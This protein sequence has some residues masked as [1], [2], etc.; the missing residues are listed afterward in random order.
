M[1]A[2]QTIFA[3]PNKF[4]NISIHTHFTTKKKEIIIFE[5]KKTRSEKSIYFCLRKVLLMVL[6]GDDDA[7]FIE[8]LFMIL[9]IY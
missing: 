9:N 1:I 2:P 8:N 3:N 4:S 5:S 7:F 6:D